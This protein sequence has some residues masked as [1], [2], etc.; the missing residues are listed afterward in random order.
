MDVD[1]RKTVDERHGRDV[2]DAQRIQRALEVQRLAGAPLSRLQGRRAAPPAL[3]AVVPVAL[4]P[5]RAQLHALIATRF[6]AMLAAGLVDELA[7]LRRR[8]ALEASMPSMRTVGY[9]QAWDVLEGRIDRAGLRA[10]GI[11]ATRQL[12]K[13]QYTWL[14]ATAAATYDPFAHDTPAAVAA[15]IE[16]ARSA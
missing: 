1:G 4:V 13:R 10:A 8:Y 12:A 5:E 9:R 11:A 2:A 6:D 7:H 16:A 3:G 14:R 15:R